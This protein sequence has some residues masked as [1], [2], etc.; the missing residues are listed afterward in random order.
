MASPNPEAPPVTRIVPLR[1]VAAILRYRARGQSRCRH[2]PS[3]FVA[4]FCYVFDIL[5]I[6]LPL[7]PTTAAR[8]HIPGLRQT[9]A[10]ACCLVAAW[11]CHQQPRCSLG[12]VSACQGPGSSLVSSTTLRTRGPHPH[13]QSRTTPETLLA[14]APASMNDA[15]R[16]RGLVA[17]TGSCQRQHCETPDRVAVVRRRGCAH[18][19]PAEPRT[20]SGANGTPVVQQQHHHHH[21]RRHVHG[22]CER[23]RLGRVEVRLLRRLDLLDALRV[24]CLRLP[25]GPHGQ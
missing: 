14:A 22:C 10:A 4:M 23:S 21:R 2:S 5:C 12:L 9:H 3:A 7:A 25:V 1:A 20:G 16:Q 18:A 24:P 13:H 19:R 15:L 8:A 11:T 17:W 6:F